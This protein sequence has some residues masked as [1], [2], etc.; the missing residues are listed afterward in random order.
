MLRIGARLALFG[1]RLETCVPMQAC[2]PRF[3]PAQRSSTRRQGSSSLPGASRLLNAQFRANR[4]S[5]TAKVAVHRGNPG[6][7]N[8]SSF[9][10]RI[11]AVRQYPGGTENLMIFRP[12]SRDIPK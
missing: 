4:A 12:L 8:P 9:G 11:G 3:L 1:W 2:V 6:S 5:V 10:R 7:L